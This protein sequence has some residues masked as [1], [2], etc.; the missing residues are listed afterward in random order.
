MSEP[1]GGSAAPTA[2]RWLVLAW[3]LWVAGACVAVLRSAVQFADRHRL[4]EDLGRMRPELHQSQIDELATSTIVFGLLWAVLAALV[5]VLLATRMLRG[6]NW[7]RVVL[8]VFGAFTAFSAAVLV[9]VV[10]VFPEELL[11]EIAGRAVSGWEVLLA[12]VG[13][14]LHAAAIVLMYLPESNRFFRQAARHRR[15]AG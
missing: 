7:A 14:V 10:P 5:Y 12:A 13:A 9:L 8:T 4:L 1:N 6:R 15:A 2:P 3:R 11:R